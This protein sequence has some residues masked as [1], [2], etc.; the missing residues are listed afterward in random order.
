MILLERSMM[1]LY[2]EVALYYSAIEVLFSFIAPSVIPVIVVM[3]LKVDMA[4]QR[5]YILNSPFFIDLY[6]QLL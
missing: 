3:P 5:K 1:S 6:C 2:Q 4:R